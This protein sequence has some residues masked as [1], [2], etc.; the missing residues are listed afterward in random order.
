MF[1]VHK[2]N[3]LEFH[4]PFIGVLFCPITILLFWSFWSDP[5]VESEN[6]FV[7]EISL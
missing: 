4:S 7:E 3:Y 2:T 6:D 5:V 1:M